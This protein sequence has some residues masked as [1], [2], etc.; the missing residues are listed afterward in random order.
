MSRYCINCG[1]AN[2]AC[3][4]SSIQTIDTDIELIILQ[5]PSEVN[6]AKGTA[7]ILNLSLPN[8]HH[9]IGEDFSLHQELNAL[10]TAKG[11]KTYLLFPSETA[12]IVQPKLLQGKESNHTI[13]VILLDGTW[14]KAYKMYQLSLN[15]QALP[16]LCLPLDISGNYKIRKSPKK[17]N[18]STA[19][20]GYQVLK[21]IQP[22]KNFEPLLASFN[23]MI[24]FY[25]QQ[26][27]E[28]IY[29]Q[30]YTDDKY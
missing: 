29:Q 2:K 23:A 3:I 19:E 24:A 1:K 28:G 13:R 27:P 4:C 12:Q 17:N 7:K 21:I 26:L 9:F 30:N 15:L 14:K 16:C 5:H 8:S 22:E 6:R 11:S 20:A 10:I 18:L 25:I